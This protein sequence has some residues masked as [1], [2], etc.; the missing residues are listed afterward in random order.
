MNLSWALLYQYRVICIKSF[1]EGRQ[2]VI[3][4]ALK[5]KIVD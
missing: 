4:E 3:W 1:R 2:V 5:G